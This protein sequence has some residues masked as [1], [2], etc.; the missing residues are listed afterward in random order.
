MN[1]IRRVRRQKNPDSRRLDVLLA[2]MEIA[3]CTLALL[4]LWMPSIMQ[5]V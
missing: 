3:L 1:E 4:N 5:V 2:I